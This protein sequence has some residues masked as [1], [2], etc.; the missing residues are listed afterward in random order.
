MSDESLDP[1]TIALLT[2]HFGYSPVAVIDDVINAVNQIMYRGTKAFAGFLFR[3]K[4]SALARLQQQQ[5]GHRDDED[6]NKENKRRSRFDIFTKVLDDEI[7]LGIA[8]MESLLETQIDLNFDRFETYTL[9]NIFHIPRELVDGGWIKLKHHEGM[10]F[11]EETANKGPEIKAKL[12]ELT[13]NIEFE[14]HIQTVLKLQLKKAAKIVES[15][16]KLKASMQFLSTTKFS[17]DDMIIIK[18][19]LAN[20]SPIDETLGLL[21]K[22]VKI[23]KSDMENISKKL[24]F[25]LQNKEFLPN[26]R[27]IIQDG[28]TVQILA[29]VGIKGDQPESGTSRGIIQGLNL[30]F[31]IDLDQA[32]NLDQANEIIQMLRNR[33]KRPRS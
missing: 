24:D 20:L 15:M 23:L 29:R 32:S 21:I 17:N 13:E 28:R 3:K 30:D 11:D 26:E 31:P 27:D 8:K 14:A 33:R 18:E 10:D 7:K 2:E 19:R 6:E 12:L 1:R 25:N 5:R 4:Q 22:Q 16:R 9:R